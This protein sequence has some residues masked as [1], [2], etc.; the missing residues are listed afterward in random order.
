MSFNLRREGDWFIIQDDETKVT[1]Q[2]KTMPEAKK[3]LD[4]AVALHKQA[5]QS[6]RLALGLNI[7]PTT[8]G[9]FLNTQEAAEVRKGM[10]MTWKIISTALSN[11]WIGVRKLFKIITGKKLE[12]I[13]VQHPKFCPNCGTEWEKCTCKDSK[14]KKY[15][16][17]LRLE[18]EAEDKAK[19]K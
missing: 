4:E 9:E 14:E 1:T 2:A 11:A 7:Q 13:P 6:A 18:R 3:M 15:W 10:A 19:L 17:A 8:K 12:P 5:T 16:D